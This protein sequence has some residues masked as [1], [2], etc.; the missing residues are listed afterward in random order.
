MPLAV[1]ALA[2]VAGCSAFGV[3]GG[4]STGGTLTPVD[5]STP[6]SGDQP[7]SSADGDA[8]DDRSPAVETDTD[9]SRSLNQQ[10]L[11][12]LDSVYGERLSNTSYRVRNRLEFVVNGSIGL[13]DL[14]RRV[15]ADERTTAG[16]RTHIDTFRVR[17]LP[18]S[19]N[20]SF[21]YVEF[22]NSSISATRYTND[23]LAEPSYRVTAEEL[24]TT[25]DLAERSRL[26]RLLLAYELEL[27][28]SS[29]GGDVLLR[30][31]H[32]AIP[33][34]LATPAPATEINGGNLTV[35]VRSNDTVSAR[36]VYNVTIGENST[37]YIVQT[38]RLDRVGEVTVQPPEWIS[39]AVREAETADRGSR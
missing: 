31:D 20:T 29:P 12:R 14:Q 2:L 9:E 7:E 39:V 33:S 36:A 13:V 38:Y 21:A 27:V 23:R 1:V 10:I 3:G 5:V 22:A 6:V 28:R 32:I 34:V 4:D 25:S 15:A 19:A 11:T 30:S 8:G 24:A 17:G 35:R 16:T 37:G 18:G 26:E